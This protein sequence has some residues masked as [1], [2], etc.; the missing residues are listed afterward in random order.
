MSINYKFRNVRLMYKAV[1]IWHCTLRRG[2]LHWY[3][4]SP[5]AHQGDP[6]QSPH[7]HA[8]HHMLSF[9]QHHQQKKRKKSQFSKFRIL[10]KARKPGKVLF[11]TKNI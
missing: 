10:K 1:M 3:G 8:S 2:I 6:Q 5:F 7:L 11:L 9:T 4:E